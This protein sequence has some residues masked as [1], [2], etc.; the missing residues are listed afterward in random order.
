VG[1]AAASLI[2]PH[3]YHE[4]VLPLEKRLVEGI[5]AAGAAVKLHICGNT[6]AIVDLMAATGADVIDL[7]WMVSLASARQRVGPRVTLCGNFD[8]CSV[9]L[10]SS[11]DQV[12]KAA[13]ECLA[14]G[15]PRFVLQPGCEVPPGTPEANIRAFCPC[16]G[17]LI[18]DLYRLGPA[19]R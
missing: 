9:L 19:E 17:C 1:D 12:A 2:G 7:D 6:S 11:P 16:E 4:G 8:P 10:Q 3:L 14:A 13:A 5:R 18:P 15:G